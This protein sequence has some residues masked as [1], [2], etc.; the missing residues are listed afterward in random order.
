MDRQGNGLGKGIDETPVCAYAFTLG[1]DD[2]FGSGQGQGIR[3]GATGVDIYL[4]FGKTA[5]IDLRH[6]RVNVS[7]DGVVRLVDGVRCGSPQIKKLF[8]KDMQGGHEGVK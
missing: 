5:P 7:L 1:S 8:G 2:I 6:G 3:L 4:T